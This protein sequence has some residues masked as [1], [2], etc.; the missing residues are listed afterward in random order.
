M[1]W[2]RAGEDGS[3]LHAEETGLVW[4]DGPADIMDDALDKIVAEFRQDWGRK[5]SR[6]ELEAG[7]R[8]SL[9]A[10]DEQETAREC[11]GCGKPEGGGHD[12][13]CPVV[14]GSLSSLKHRPEEA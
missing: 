8:F 4:G 5:P 6:I 10:Y 3:S 7:L 14:T 9:G 12:A 11:I 1:G 13:W 2:W